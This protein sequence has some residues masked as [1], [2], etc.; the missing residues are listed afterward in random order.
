[1]D[2]QPLWFLLFLPLDGLVTVGSVTTAIGSGLSLKDQN[3]SRG[4]RAAAFTMAGLQLT[5][6]TIVRSGNSGRLFPE[7]LAA[8]SPV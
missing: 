8:L 3:P 4:W 7:T 2:E 6:A 1:M 5:M